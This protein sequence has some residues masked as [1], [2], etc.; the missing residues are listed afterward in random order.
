MKTKLFFPIHFLTKKIMI[1]NVN[2]GSLNGQGWGVIDF[3]H[4]QSA[5]WES[6]VCPEITTG[7]NGWD[8][9]QV[10]WERM[11]RKKSRTFCYSPMS[12]VE[13]EIF[14]IWPLELSYEDFP[15]FQII[16]WIFFI[17]LFF[18]IHYYSLFFKIQ[19]ADR[20]RNLSHGSRLSTPSPGLPQQMECAQLSS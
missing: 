8:V 12:R 4:N 11:R 17:K 3:P 1:I 20:V 2:T 7:F 18:K 19:K 14:T 10:C 13:Y 6:T 15:V 5:C 16:F 9:P